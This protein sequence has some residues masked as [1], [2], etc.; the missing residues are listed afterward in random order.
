MFT[1]TLN[2]IRNKVEPKHQ[3]WVSIT[4]QD[5]G[6]IDAIIVSYDATK[7]GDGAVLTLM[8]ATT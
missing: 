2:K 1:K 5:N 8:H 4:N 7:Q 6:L 3:Y